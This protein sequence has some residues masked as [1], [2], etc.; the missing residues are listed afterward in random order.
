[1]DQFQ[2][3]E[4]ELRDKIAALDKQ[5][6]EEKERFEKEVAD[7]NALAEAERKQRIE[8]HQK[9]EEEHR[10]RKE[11][12]LAAIAQQKREAESKQR[13]AE[14]ASNAAEE[15]KRE[16]ERKLQWL[17]DEIAKQEFIEEQH[18]KT[19]ETAKKVPVVPSDGT[20][21]TINVEHPVAPDNKGNAVVGTE[22]ATPETPLMSHHLKQILRQATRQY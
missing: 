1:M 4:K 13:D 20:E 19:L 17:K 15:A 11:K 8:E 5:R 21:P 9:R 12:E 22:G 10:Q 18:R 14:L 3:L 7:R 6:K 2:A 16:Q